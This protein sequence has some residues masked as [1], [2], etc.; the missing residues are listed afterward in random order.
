M[1]QKMKKWIAFLFAALLIMLVL[2][3]AAFAESAPPADF[4]IGSFSQVDAANNTALFTV[5]DTNETTTVKLDASINPADV[6]LDQKSMVSLEERDGTQFATDISIMFIGLTIDKLIALLIVGFV[7]GLLSGFIGSGGAF[8][9][10]PAMMSLGAPGAVAVASNM[11]HKFPKAMVGAYK[12]F[13]YGQ[14]DIKLGLVIALSSIAG[15]QL[16]FQIQKFILESWGSAGSDL[17][18][19][20]VFVIILVV[21][22]GIVF[23]DALTGAKGEDAEAKTGKLALRLQ[24]IKIPPM[25]HFKKADVVI[26]AWVTIPVGFATGLLAATIAVG[27]FVGVPGMV[28]VIGATAMVASATEL[29]V[30]FVMG[31]WG[32]IQWAL[33]GLVDIRMV[34]LILAASLFG[35]Q[36]GAIGTTYV[37]DYTIKLVMGTVM[38]I[39]AVSRGVKVPVYMSHLGMISIDK[40]LSNTLDTISFWALI[41]ALLVAGGIIIAA[42]VKGIIRARV[43]E[44]E[45]EQAIAGNV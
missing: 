4:K 29:L 39:V 2:A 3:P 11:C 15:V 33:N 10:T 14:V 30:A 22:G 41:A 7:G 17:Y 6:K 42:M 34:L 43:D 27:G 19:S 28:Y 18:V 8:V 23:K 32:S 13:R 20:F 26:S 45:A 36:L 12:R 35:V 21:V 40:G 44:R 24:K 5:A 31:M 16:G 25:I 9:L 1:E 37:K 38:I